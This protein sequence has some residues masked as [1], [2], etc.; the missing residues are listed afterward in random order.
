MEQRLTRSHAD[1][2]LTGVAGGM[3][4][5]FDIDPVILRLLWVLAAIF[6]GSLLL[7]IYFVMAII[8]PSP[9]D[10]VDEDEGHDL[11]ERAADSQTETAADGARRA[12]QR[13]RGAFA[14]GTGL[15]LIGGLALISQF[16]WISFWQFWPLILI[17]IGGALILSR[18]R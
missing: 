5:Y 6:S 3:A 4:E 14:I 18:W 9:G 2:M 10:D 16:G 13:G 12:R 17:G 11:A 15:I 8:M 7:I 1:R